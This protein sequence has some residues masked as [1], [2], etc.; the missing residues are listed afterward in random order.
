[1]SSFP[2][3]VPASVFGALDALRNK[4]KL[5]VDDLKLMVL[6]KAGSGPFY[7]ELAELAPSRVAKALLLRNGVE[8]RIQ[9]HRLK[10]AIEIITGEPY[11]IPVLTENPFAKLEVPAC[12]ETILEV[13]EML[14][15]EGNAHLERWADKE[16]NSQ[17][18]MILAQSACEDHL[19]GERVRQVIAIL[20]RQLGTE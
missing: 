12:S 14:E 9:A 7:D 17:V 18:A 13:V 8:E 3:R 5:D 20:H 19:H 11:T 15:R 16:P 6:L 2:N 10:R 4:D 1:M